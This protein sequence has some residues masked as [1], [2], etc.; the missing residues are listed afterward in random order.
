[1]SDS[2]GLGG[3]GVFFSVCW[4]AGSVESFFTGSTGV[5]E[6]ASSCF[7]G[8]GADARKFHKLLTSKEAR[9]ND[10]HW[11]TSP[12]SSTKRSWPTVTVSSSFASNFMIVPEVGAFTEM[13]IYEAE[14]R[15]TEEYQM[16]AMYD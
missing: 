12:A 8:G 10:V 2:E 14:E 5:F 6:G 3:G 11:T 9:S 16:E 7:S 15:N 1:M 4:S 13:S